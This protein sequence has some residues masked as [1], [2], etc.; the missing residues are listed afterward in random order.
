M[1]KEDLFLKYVFYEM[2][3]AT[4]KEKIT[5]ILIDLVSDSEFSDND[6]DVNI[7]AERLKTDVLRGIVFRGPEPK[8][9]LWE[10]EMQKWEEE[11]AADEKRYNEMLEEM[12]EERRWNVKK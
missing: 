7:A 5:S 1:S 8:K 9:F 4:V 2:W 11:D 10:E 3:S 12:S 6:L